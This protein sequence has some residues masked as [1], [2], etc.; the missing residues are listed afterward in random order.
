MA[1]ILLGVCYRPP[2]QDEEVGAVFYKRLAEVSQSLA[3]FL[4]GDLYLPDICWKNN[5]A[6]REQSRRFLECVGDNFVRQLV[7]EP[8]RGGASLDLLFTNREQVRGGVVGCHLGLSDHEMIR[9]P[10]SR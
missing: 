2:N 3:L 1:D 9:V 5:T 10:G 7:S 6:E 4:V 8:S